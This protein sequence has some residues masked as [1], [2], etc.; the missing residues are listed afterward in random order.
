MKRRRRAQP[1]DAPLK[2]FAP[3]F[4]RSR[5]HVDRPLDS[6]TAVEIRNAVYAARR[7]PR[8]VDHFIINEPAG[9]RLM[10]GLIALHRSGAVELLLWT[11]TA[12]PESRNDL[13]LT[14]V[15]IRKAGK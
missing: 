1:D 9:T 10:K 12:L 8:G 11:L 5:H 13:Y 3:R 7:L 14:E 4:L 6:F 2:V 15:K